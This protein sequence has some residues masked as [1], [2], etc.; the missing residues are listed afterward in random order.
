ME[1]GKV[2]RSKSLEPRCPKCGGYDIDIAKG[3][4]KEGNTTKCKKCGKVSAFGYDGWCKDCWEKDDDTDYKEVHVREDREGTRKH[5]CRKC[6]NY[7]MGPGDDNECPHCGASEFAIN[8]TNEKYSDP[9][10]CEWCGKPAPG[11][12]LCTSCRAKQKAEWDAPVDPKKAGAINRDLKKYGLKEEYPLTTYFAGNDKD[13]WVLMHQGQPLNANPQGGIPVDRE[14]VQRVAKQ[15]G[16]KNV[17]VWNGKNYTYA[18]ESYADRKDVD[19]GSYGDRQEYDDEGVKCTQ[20]KKS[21]N[22]VQALMGPVCGD[23]TRKNH[24]AAIKGFDK[25]YTKARGGK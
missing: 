4:L 18:F 7:W 5:T 6:Y 8:Q 10:G 24:A 22:P 21:M 19:G 2:F 13:G 1:C 17:M 23:C 12:L 3:T 9:E 11:S 14:R 25:A 16:F 15:F 20:C